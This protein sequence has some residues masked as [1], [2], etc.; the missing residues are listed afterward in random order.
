MNEGGHHMG[1]AEGKLV[2]RAIEIGGR[3]TSPLPAKLPPMEADRN[4]QKS[5]RI[6]IAFVRE[7]RGS[8]AVHT[9]QRQKES[10]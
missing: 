4:L 3:D 1:L 2:V 5:L 10:A 6:R 7:M 8:F 9:P